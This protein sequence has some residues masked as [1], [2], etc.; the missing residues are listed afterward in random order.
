MNTTVKF[1]VMNIVFHGCTS[2]NGFDLYFDTVFNTQS[3]VYNDNDNYSFGCELNTDE[4]ASP[5][6][7]IVY[8]VNFNS[9]F[10][11]TSNTLFTATQIITSTSHVLPYYDIDSSLPAIYDEESSAGN[12]YPVA[13]TT[14][15]HNTKYKL[16]YMSINSF[17]PCLSLN[18]LLLNLLVVNPII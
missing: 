4:M 10:N 6:Y 16:V 12:D 17:F 3:L 2:D 5:V 1:T 13:T 18:H 8:N 11:T 9:L 15:S 14:M 7:D